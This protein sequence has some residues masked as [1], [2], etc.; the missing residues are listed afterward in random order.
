MAALRRVKPPPLLTRHL[1]A[2]A[3][4]TLRLFSTSVLP[5]ASQPQFEEEYNSSLYNLNRSQN[6]QAAEALE[7][8]T[9]QPERGVQFAL[10]GHIRGRCIFAEKLSKLLEV[11]RISIASLVRQDLSPKSLLYKQI[12]NA[13]NQGTLVP[14]D[15]VFALLAKRLE[16]GYYRGETGFIL[17]GIP[18][19]QVQAEILDQLVDIDLVVNFKCIEKDLQ[20]NHGSRILFQNLALEDYYKKQMKLLNFQVCPAPE[21][22]WEGLLAAL[23]L[24]HVTAA[25]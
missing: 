24:Q 5:T 7:V 21:E 22:T 1:I 12:A 9:W 11:P 3:P 13:V 6:V 2:A 17:D 4:P 8:D 19:T 14:E 10:I 23:H 20:D 15:I 25:H 18:R 16:D